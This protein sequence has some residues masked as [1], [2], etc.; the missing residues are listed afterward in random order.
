M[1]T[2]LKAKLSQ[3]YILLALLSISLISVLTNLFLETQFKEYIKANQQKKNQQFLALMGQQYRENG[4]WNEEH[5]ED[6]GVNALE[7]GLIIRVYTANQEIVWDATT[8]NN[9]MCQQMLYH[10]AQNMYSRYPNFQGGYHE[11]F[12]DIL[13]NGIR[14]GK[15][16]VGYYGPFYFND[17]DLAF[18]NTLNKIF[19]GVGGASFLFAI[20]FGAWMSRHL[21]AGISCVMKRAKKIAQGEYGEAYHAH[22]EIR[23]IWELNDSM[24]HLAQTLRR[25]ENMRK[26]LTA[27]VAHELR[28]PLSTLQSHMEAMIDGIWEPTEERL[29]SCHEE[30]IRL[31]RMVGDLSRLAQYESDNMILNKTGFY[32]P[33]LVK[34][35]ILNFEKAFME[36][37]IAVRIEEIPVYIEADKDKISQVIINLLSNA[38]KYTPSGGQVRIHFEDREEQVKMKIHDTGIGIEK[39]HLPFIFDRFYRVDQSRNRSTGGAGIGL[40][41]VKAVVDAHQGTVEV[42]SELGKGTEFTILLPK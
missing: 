25:Q 9:G 39:E 15:M 14:V 36:K 22:S 7:Q 41:V 24:D 23:E 12:Y 19:L 40:A 8:H 28:T 38:L 16:T 34:A 10:M 35:L 6:I 17:N 13:S 31:S 3:S 4:I 30:I 11:D 32:L 29:Q 42:K 5:I 27:D 20:L 26:Q 21:S 33:E 18:L 2:S 1:K 37:D